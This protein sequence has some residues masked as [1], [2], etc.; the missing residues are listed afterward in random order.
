MTTTTTTSNWPSKSQLS[1][2][3]SKQKSRWPSEDAYRDAAS[4]LSLDTAILKAF[5]VVEAGS[6]GAFLDTDEPVILFERHHFHKHTKGVYDGIAAPDLPY[7]VGVL[8]HPKPGGYGPVKI[9]HIKL[10][11]AAKLD[12]VAALKSASW[13][14]FQILGSNYA[15]AGHA[16]LQSFINAA[17]HSADD[18]LAMLVHFILNNNKLLNALR[19]KD[20]TTAAR[21]YNGPR[22]KGYDTRLKQAYLEQSV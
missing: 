18:H 19:V 12:R 11:A 7:S 21:I 2:L 15:E 1:A 8:S 13:G 4:K 6:Y 16:T 3:G 14:L 22:Q 9:Q 20:W 5:A 10:A 17:Y